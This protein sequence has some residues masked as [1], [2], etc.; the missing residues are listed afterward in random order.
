[1]KCN[2]ESSL[3]PVTYPAQ[4]HQLSLLLSLHSGKPPPLNISIAH[5]VHCH[6]DIFHKRNDAYP[7]DSKLKARQYV[8]N[9]MFISKN[10]PPLYM[11][12]YLPTLTHLFPSNHHLFGSLHCV[13]LRY[14]WCRSSSSKKKLYSQRLLHWKI[15]NYYLFRRAKVSWYKLLNSLARPSYL[16]CFIVVVISLSQSRVYHYFKEESNWSHKEI[17]KMWSIYLV[18]R[19]GLLQAA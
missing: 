13:F 1:M 12:F 10:C 16:T 11:Y 6:P 7:T 5:L 3:I 2:T 9:N 19:I 4:H 17:N 8:C 15:C 18:W 14:T